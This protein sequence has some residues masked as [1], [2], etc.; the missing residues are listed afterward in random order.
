MV[1]GEACP[2]SWGAVVAPAA[3]GQRLRPDR[4]DGQ[5]HVQPPAF[6]RGRSSI[7]GPLGNARAY[8]LDGRLEPVPPGVTGEL[9]MPGLEWREAT[10]GGPG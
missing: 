8:V 7:G 2:G 10:W 4:D 9:Y 3:D 5:R 1:G 6:G